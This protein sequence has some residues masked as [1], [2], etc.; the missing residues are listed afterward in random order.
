MCS[1]KVRLCLSELNI[2]YKSN[3]I[4][5]SEEGVYGNLTDEFLKINPNGTVPALVY[6]GM[7]VLE[8]HEIIEFID[9]H[10]RVNDGDTPRLRPLDVKSR[11]LC[12]YWCKRGSLGSTGISED[13]LNEYVGLAIGILSQPCTVG[14]SANKVNL[15]ELFWAIPRHPSPMRVLSRFFKRWFDRGLPI[16][17]TRRAFQAVSS[18][19]DEMETHLMTQQQQQQQQANNIY[20]LCGEKYTLADVTWT[21]NL[22]RLVDLQYGNIIFKSRPYVKQYWIQLKERSSY[23]EAIKTF[24]LPFFQKLMKEHI[25]Y[26]PTKYDYTLPGLQQENQQSKL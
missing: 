4:K 24:Q 15:L 8:S 11:E 10:L 7:P 1:E 21:A 18:V 16:E 13:E 20:F 17:I 6:K 19:L 5:L 9:E 12:D 2:K 22:N 25:P 26:D 14:A 3:I 23:N